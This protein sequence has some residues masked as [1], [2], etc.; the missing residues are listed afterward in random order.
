M[1]HYCGPLFLLIIALILPAPSLPLSSPSHSAILSTNPLLLLIDDALCRQIIRRLE[2]RVY[3]S[4]PFTSSL[5]DPKGRESTYDYLLF[6]AGLLRP[7]PVQPP[8]PGHVPKLGSAAG[9]A[10]QPIFTFA[11]RHGLV[12]GGIVGYKGQGGGAESNFEYVR[13]GVRVKDCHF[14]SSTGC[15]SL[16]ERGCGEVAELIYA[17]IFGT[18][19]AR[20]SV[21]PEWKTEGGT[22]CKWVFGGDGGEKRNNEPILE[23][24]KMFVKDER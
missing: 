13:D 3:S 7:T 19:G 11:F 22:G 4:P 8:E 23:S 21:K 20:L 12:S 24:C 1:R 9:K 14:L 16:C 15:L 5:P 2:T 17:E 18:E 6:L 10:F